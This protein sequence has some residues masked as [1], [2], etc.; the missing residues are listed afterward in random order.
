MVTFITLFLGLVTGVQSVQL[1]VDGPVARVE[2]LLDHETVAVTNGPPWR[3]R[4]DFGDRIVPNELVA[5][6]FDVDGREIHRAMQVVNLPRPL[7]EIQVAFE[8]RADGMP[9]AARLFWDNSDDSEPLSVFAILDGQYLIP[10]TTGRYQ[11]PDYDPT[12]IHIVSAEA[13]FANE[14]TARTDMTFGGQYGARVNT[15]L[16]AIPIVVKGKPPSPEDLDEAFSIR[17][18]RLRVAVVEQPSA[19]IYFVRDFASMPRMSH[20]RNRQDRLFPVPPRGRHDAFTSPG[21][22]PDEDRLHVV[23]P[24][25]TQ[26]RNR[27]LFPTSQG[28]GLDRW[29][30]RWLATRLVGDGAALAGQKLAEAVAVAGVQAAAQGTPRAVLALV[31]DNPR[32]DSTFTILEIRRYLEQ[33]R[34]PLFI[35]YVGRQAPI[36]WGP[37]E[38]VSTQRGL[39][40][41]SKR[42]SKELD[43]QWIVWVEG[44]HMINQIELD[45]SATGIRLAGVN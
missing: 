19:Q 32:D 31:S 18:N 4:C 7:A 11:F 14:V 26:R 33:I 21:P 12:Q 22:E 1:A 6:A 39:S 13:R 42:L 41:A 8:T 16:T 45:A 28:I 3:V 40:A 35:W 37:C 2:L 9:G 30:L 38:D 43:R 25:P 20:I 24:N 44:S 10:D 36:A 34:V 17:G 29:P 23:V 15:E 27:Q 5:V